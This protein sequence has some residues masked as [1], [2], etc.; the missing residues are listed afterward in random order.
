[1]VVAVDFRVQPPQKIDV[2]AL[3]P[4][5]KVV[6]NVVVPVPSEVFNGL[7]KLG[8]RP[9]WADVLR[10]TKETVK[11]QGEQVQIA[12]QMGV[13]IAEGFIAPCS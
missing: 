8:P 4:A 2:S 13:V 7:D 9:N 6:E 10:P 12:L 3:P 5:A 11:V 1:M